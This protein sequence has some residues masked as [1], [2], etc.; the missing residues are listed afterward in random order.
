MFPEDLRG[1]QLVL[2]VIS[3]CEGSLLFWR[4]LSYY[5]TGGVLLDEHG[6]VKDKTG[7][8]VRRNLALMARTKSSS[9]S[10]QGVLNFSTNGM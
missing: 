1:R 3:F 5:Y 7:D 9:H 6:G 2:L 8:L 4:A 10:N